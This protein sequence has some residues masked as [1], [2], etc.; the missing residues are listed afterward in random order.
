MSPTTTTNV[1]AEMLLAF[2]IDGTLLETGRP[3]SDNVIREARAAVKAGHHF[4]LATGR[5]L[6]GAVRAAQ[7]LG[8]RGGWI[9]SSNGAVTARIGDGK[10][11]I[12]ERHLVD[13]EAVVRYVAPKVRL[14]IAA[15]I[16][17]HGYRTA[18]VF[19][20][21]ELSGALYPSNLE[22]LWSAPTPRVA[23]VGEG[24]AWL[25][26]GLRQ[27]GVTAHAVNA[28]WVDITRG[29][30]SKASALE[31]VRTALGISATATV[32]VGDSGNDLEMLRWAARGVAM[33]H[34]PVHVRQSANEVTG[35][36]AQDGAAQV[37][38]SIA[39]RSSGRH[40]EPG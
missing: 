30:V 24:A 6:V 1:G 23:L 35:T 18:G 26:D 12:V 39:G 21:R 8:L 20:P 38:R 28:E 10:V 14:R 34:A 22:G 37:L 36:L 29:G 17:G 11:T 40:S 25:V 7:Q 33:A 4:V 15:E 9:V 3:P 31:R 19:G 2:D 16:P 5:S 13:V 27:M 32:A